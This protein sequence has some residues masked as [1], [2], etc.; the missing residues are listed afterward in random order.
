MS[1][2]DL[3]GGLMV[4]LGCFFCIVGAVGMLRFPDFYT[5]THAASI[6][7]TLGAGL[8]LWGLM[9]I[10]GPNLV[11][12]KL[13]MVAILVLVTSPTAGHALVKAAYANGVAWT[14]KDDPEASS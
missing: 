11:T 12:V 9:I 1:P 10:S 13:L 3:I 7:D 5:R 14:R 2:F 6:T 8:V 4:L